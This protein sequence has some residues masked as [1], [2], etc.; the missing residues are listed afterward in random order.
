MNQLDRKS[1]CR[2]IDRL[3]DTKTIS[4]ESR[5]EILNLLGLEKKTGNYQAAPNELQQYQLQDNNLKALLAS[6][7]CD[8]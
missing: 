6:T 8:A 5:D 1:I 3:V 7:D 4:P 2:V